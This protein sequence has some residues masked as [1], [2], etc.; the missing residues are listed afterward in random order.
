MPTSNIIKGSSA[1]GASTINASKVIGTFTGEVFLDKVTGDKDVSVAHVTF[2]PCARTHWHTHERGQI[3]KVVV[4]SG[5]VCDKGGKPQRLSVGDVVWAEP[6]TEHWHGADEGSMM[7]H[8]AIGLGE[9]KWN[10]PVT[11]EEYGATAKQ[12]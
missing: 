4:G 9:T 1:P 2:L 10:D 6:G 3:L 11:E 5:W 8:L 7:C 12:Q